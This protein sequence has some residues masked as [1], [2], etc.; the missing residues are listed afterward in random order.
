MSSLK[1][2]VSVLVLFALVSFVPQSF[3]QISL[4]VPATQEDVRVTITEDGNVHVVHKIASST[5]AQ[6]LDLIEGTV[7]DLKVTDEEG[8]DVEFA[9]VGVVGVSSIVM[10]PTGNESLS[11]MIFLM[12]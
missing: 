5:Q 6:D 12:C 11:S 2:I 8:N 3:A 7:S 1:I 10:F 4:G 9:K